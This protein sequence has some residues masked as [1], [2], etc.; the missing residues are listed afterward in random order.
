[1]LETP[2]LT[3]AAVEPV[4]QTAA[5]ADD[6]LWFKDAVIYQAHV[7]SFFDSNNDG[8]GDFQGLT[9]K[10]DYLQDLGVTCLWLLPFFPSP[11]RDDG[12]DIS[13]YL[14]IHPSYGTL[15]DFQGLV[16]A[17]HARHIKILI[18]LVVNHT[19]DQ[20]PWFQRAR[21][22][23]RGSPEREFYV[24]SDSDKKFPET[25]I[26]F[27]DTE[28]SNWAYDPVAGQYYWH[29]FFSHQPDLNHNN[30][31][32]VD[33]VIDVMKFWLE[34]GVDALRLD[35]VPYLCVREGTNNENL[36]E[37]HAVLKRIRRELDAAFKN[38]MLLAEANQWPSDVSAYFG[39]GDECHMAFHFPLMPRMF[40]AIR[41][42]DRHAITEILSQTPEIPDNCQ[43]AL[44]LRNHDELTLEMVTDEERDYMYSV[45]AADPQMRLN[46]GIRRRLAPLMENSRRRVELMHA[47]LFSFPGTPI[48]YYGDEIG[49]G[50]NI[51]LGDR[52]GV[53]TPMQ[54]SSDRN[55]GFSRADPARLYAPP[56]QDPVYGYQSINVEAQERYPFSLLNWMK[57][58]IAMRRQHRAL[59]RGSLE[60]VH[61]PNRKVLAYLRSDDRETILC[62][63]NLSRSVQPAELHLQAQAGLIPVEMLGLTE[64][65]R[66]TDRPYFLTLGAYASYWFTLQREPMQRAAR[67]T[68]SEDARAAITG[69]LPALLMGVDWETALES[70]TRAVMER[71]A[72]RP[73]LQRQRWFGSKSR[74]IKQ[75]RFS[76]WGAVRQGKNPAFLTIVSLEYTDGWTESYFVPLALLADADAERAVLDNPMAVLARI[77]GARKGAIID[78][79]YDDDMCGRLLELVERGGELTTS[80]GSAHGLMTGRPLALDSDRRWTRGNG[81]QSN[82]LAFVNDRYLLKLFR[83]MEPTPNPEFEIGSVLTRRGFSRTPALMGAIEYL[84]PNLEPGTLAVVQTVV[85]HQGSGWE[86]TVDEL[87]RFYERVSARVTESRPAA[88]S[89]A[90][91][92]LMAGP[93]EYPAQPVR[94]PAA[95]LPLHGTLDEPPPFFAALENWYLASATTLGR[96]TAEL[97]LSLADVPGA[98]FVPEPL[99]AAALSG[100]ADDMQARAQT[101][102]GLLEQR[103]GTLNETAQPY[104]DAVLTRRHALLKRF[105]ELR[106]LDRAGSCMRIHGD[107]HLGQVLRTEEDFVILDFEGE[108]ERSIAQRRA[109][110]SP[111][112]DVAGMIRSYSYAAYAALFAFTIHTLD[113]Q[114]VLEPWADTWQYWVADAFLS[115]Y[116][117]TLGSSALVPQGEGWDR[118]LRAFVIDKALYELRY[119]LNHRPDWVRIPLVGINKLISSIGD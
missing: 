71:Q 67:V 95:G 86:F 58:L 81:D 33:A 24:W 42:E 40:M 96:R 49:M 107:Y 70:G 12:Y 109:K 55:G 29:R 4:V 10:L 119:E 19:S 60:F 14:N 72:L 18:E 46:L 1:M 93:S 80:R 7:K 97:H 66:I 79:A 2:N 108:P 15:N 78:G 47:M 84:R 91:Q 106:S 57:R 117:T 75:A 92:T 113:A 56:I 54:W 30:P 118:M 69:E 43:W 25:R 83:R 112:R 65:P 89:V 116:R 52:N 16:R 68:A 5:A 34:F 63:V 114:Q 22:A 20:H 27:L 85:K 44:F 3:A 98:A 100:L 77:T 76:D 8:I 6:L 73:F 26:I 39:D 94:L 36:P 104:A 115:G 53:R 74:E 32:V 105:D 51:Y 41:Q 31:A 48:V 61:C 37:T 9:Q 99:E 111:L 110:Q 101:T 45:Y 87:R 11:L 50:D 38:R 62:I 13:D 64:F 28:K 90:A 59:G 23:P 21:H 102:L 88:G 35:A 103:I 17:A 82:S